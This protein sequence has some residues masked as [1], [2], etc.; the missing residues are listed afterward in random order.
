MGDKLRARAAMEKAGVPV[1][2]G[3]RRRGRASTRSS[4]RR[5]AASGF[6]L[7]IKAS[8][9]G[10]G[11]G[12]SRVDAHRGASGGARGGPPARGG[13]VR[14]RHGVPRASPRGLPP[15]R[16]PGLR[17]HAR[18][19]M[20]SLF[21]RE[22]SVQR[23]HQKILEETP[24]P[25]LD[26]GLRRAMGEAAV[27]A[28]R[29]VGYVGRGH[30]RVS[31]RRRSRFYFLEMNTRLQVEHPITEETLGCDLV[32]AQLEVAAGAPLP[33][34][35]DGRVAP[36]AGATRSSCGSTPRTPSS[37][38]PAPGRILVYR[39]PSGPGIRVDCRS[40]GGKRSS[41]STTTRCSPSS[42]S[43]GEPRARR[44]SR[45][46][47]AR[48]RGVD[49]SRRRDERAAPLA[50]SSS[51]DAFVSGPLRQTSSASSRPRASRN[52]RTRA[53]IAAALAP[54]P[55]ARARMCR[56]RGSGPGDIGSVDRVSV[57]G[58]PAREGRSVSSTQDAFA[59]CGSIER[60]PARRT[61]R[62]T[63]S[64]S[65]P[66]PAGVREILVDGR[67]FRV[68]T[69]RAAE[70]GSGSGARARSYDFEIGTRV[71]A[72]GRDRAPSAASRRRCPGRVRRLRRRRRRVAVS[73]AATCSSFSKR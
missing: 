11:K 59:R 15:R 14:R 28:A 10:G 30:G 69:A 39:E 55:A 41:A 6:P 72:G 44:R 48:S 53:W 35:V 16:V 36:A 68:A 57:R 38:C 71:A 1:V 64:F 45:G 65:R 4:S 25:A 43:A 21:E 13:G 37:S 3:S 52:R 49:R 5:R 23:R 2:P 34:S 40:R 62:D 60:G 67:R 9:G 24:S 22:C 58:G 32:R 70:T 26:D 63:R 46:R 18:E 29:A 51:S 8:A 12:M 20:V 54:W 27:A 61:H 31:R 50:R 73:K 66:R 17:R 7:L 47:G 33:A 19:T 56:E 42:S